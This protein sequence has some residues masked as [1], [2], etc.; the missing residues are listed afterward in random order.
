[1][2]GDA[3]NETAIPDAPPAAARPATLTVDF[4]EDPE[5]TSSRKSAAEVRGSS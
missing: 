1:M 4:Y 2:S 3:A 5:R